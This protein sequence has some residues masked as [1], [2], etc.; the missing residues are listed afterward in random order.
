MRRDLPQHQT[1]APRVGPHFHP[2]YLMLAR[3]HTAQRRDQ[4]VSTHTGPIYRTLPATAPF[5]RRQRLLPIAPPSPSPRAWFTWIMGPWEGSICAKNRILV[6]AKGA[7][8]AYI[9]LDVIASELSKARKHKPM[10]MRQRH[11]TSSTF[12]RSRKYPC[13]S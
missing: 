3:L 4:Q 13:G 5:T 12:H 8:R 6:K 10:N 7:L 2:P 11:A 1:R 9:D